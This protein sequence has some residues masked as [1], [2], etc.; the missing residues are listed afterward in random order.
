[1]HNYTVTGGL[2]SGLRITTAVGNAWNT[3]MTG[4]VLKVLKDIGINTEDVER[5]IRGDDSA[6]FTNTAAKGMLVKVGYDIVGAKGGEGKF[7]LQ[8]GKME[9][10]RVWYD[11]KCSGYPM[12][13]LPNLVQRK[14]WSSEAW[15]PD[16]VIRAI[17]ETIR[18]LR[19]R[20]PHRLT[21]INRLWSTLSGDWCRDHRVPRQ[22]LSVPVHMGGFA[23][24]GGSAQNLRIVPR[25]HTVVEKTGLKVLNQTTW[26]K[27]QKQKYFA[28]TYNIAISDSRASQLAQ[29][30]LISTLVSDDIPVVAKTCRE[31]WKK[32]TAGR[33]YR[34]EVEQSYPHTQLDIFDVNSYPI[35]DVKTMTTTL[36]ARAPLF[37]AYPELQTALQDYH[38]LEPQ[39]TLTSWLEQHYPRAAHVLKLFHNSWYL[40]EKLDYLTGKLPITP[41]VLHPALNKV[42]QMMVA[43]NFS[44]RRKLIRSNLQVRATAIERVLYQSNLSQRIYNW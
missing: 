21:Q 10:L 30:Q 9:F 41:E 29:N 43:Q 12:R 24:E 1:M 31:Q 33:T 35:E 23:I 25:V 4:L 16:Y 39:A 13:A 32:D 3:V 7:S 11:T 34:V 20:S 15:T 22:S 2:M 5:Y 17:Y 8:A 44:P 14:P 26:R 36:A 38:E 42:W 18:T 19:R 27:D 37:G 40:G 28:E 6:I